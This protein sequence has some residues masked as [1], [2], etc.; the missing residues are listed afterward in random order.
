MAENTY[1]TTPAG[2]VWGLL[3][4]ERAVRVWA[5]ETALT[6]IKSCGGEMSASG[7]VAYA[8]ELERYVAE[9]LNPPAEVEEEVE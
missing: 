7:L 1:N 2:T 9:G 6:K 3:N 5:V 8:A 4:Q